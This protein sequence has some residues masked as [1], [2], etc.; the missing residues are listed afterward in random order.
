MLA[1]KRE[2]WN[3]QRTAV[4]LAF[5]CGYAV[6]AH[7]AVSKAWRL[8]VHTLFY[9]LLHFF[10]IKNETPWISKSIV[11]LDPRYEELWD[12]LLLKNHFGKEFNYAEHKDVQIQSN[13]TGETCLTLDKENLFFFFFFKRQDEK[14]RKITS[15]A[16]FTLEHITKGLESR[17]EILSQ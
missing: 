14:G 4:Y 11:V 3:K 17:K 16:I 13:L 15:I 6:S 1:K 8:S 9:C 2:R 5:L 10:V 7:R 12:V